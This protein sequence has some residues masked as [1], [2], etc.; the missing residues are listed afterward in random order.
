M[1]NPFATIELIIQDVFCSGEDSAVD[2]F[3][4]KSMKPQPLAKE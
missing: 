4:Y 1:D 3:Y 2:Q